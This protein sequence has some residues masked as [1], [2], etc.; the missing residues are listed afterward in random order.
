M[1]I[2]HGQKFIHTYSKVGSRGLMLHEKERDQSNRQ[3]NRGPWT[4]QT[5]GLEVSD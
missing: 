1:D 4:L 5:V 3:V 2:P